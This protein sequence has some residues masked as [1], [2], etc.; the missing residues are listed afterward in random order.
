MT[1]PRGQLSASPRARFTVAALVFGCLALSWPAPAVASRSTQARGP[2]MAD[3]QARMLGDL[4]P[5]PGSSRLGVLDRA[6]GRVFFSADDGTHGREPWVSDGSPTGTVMVAD[7]QPGR[8]GSASILPEFVPARHGVVF[9]T[10]N[11]DAVPPG[12]EPIGSMW[13]TTATGTLGDVGTTTRLRTGPTLLSVDGTS[14]QGLAL[15]ATS[16]F[17]DNA[18]VWRS[19]GTVA[20]TRIVRQ[21]FDLPDDLTA[22]DGVTYFLDAQNPLWRTDGTTPGTAKVKMFPDNRFGSTALFNLTAVGAKVYFTAEEFRR[23][24]DELGVSDGSRT[25][26][27]LVKN[28]RPGVAGSRPGWLTARGRRLYFSANDGVHGSQLW[29]TNGT[30][31]GTVRLT[32]LPGRPLIQ[33]VTSCRGALYFTAT[34][35][36]GNELWARYGHPVRTHQ[37]ADLALGRASSHPRALTCL[38]GGLAFSADDGVHGRELW[39]VTRP[40][41]KAVLHDLSPTGSSLPSR[42]VRVGSKVFFTANDGTHGREPWVLTPAD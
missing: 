17:G 25:G 27:H 2:G 12:V 36:R 14:F 22:A 6:R 33:H 26:T 11:S 13:S 20:G 21:H 38:N 9:L 32:N 5:G 34:G 39:T 23:A 42:L 3:P 4:H 8:A 16:D 28:I 10:D 31:R 1:A 18:Q 7:L 35:Q 40:G 41:A 24:G 15:L 19:D 29:R 30:R 37:I